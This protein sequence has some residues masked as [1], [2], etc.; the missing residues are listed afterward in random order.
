M[1]FRGAQSFSKQCPKCGTTFCWLCQTRSTSQ[2]VCSQCHY[3]FVVKRGIPPAARATKNREITQYVTIKG[4]LHRIASI[5]APGAGHISVGHF[6]VGLPV[7]LV[8]A[9]SAG[10]LIT[11]RY[12]APNLV[13]D[14]PLGPRLQAGFGTLAVLTYLVAQAVKPRAQMVAPAPRRVRPEEGA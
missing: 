4:L 8:W 6:N 7:L 13:A 10:G 9:I 1:R 3:L 14:A 11:I 5:V 12:L 2:D